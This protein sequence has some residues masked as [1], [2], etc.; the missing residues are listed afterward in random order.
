[1]ARGNFQNTETDEHALVE[2]ERRGRRDQADRT[3]L[4][5]PRLEDVPSGRA[6]LMGEGRPAN[7]SWNGRLSR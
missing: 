1:M 3:A 7:S 5:G 2:Q 6:R 4:V